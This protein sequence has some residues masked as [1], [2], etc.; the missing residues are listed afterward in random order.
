[1][2]FCPGF[3][4]LEGDLDNLI[5]KYKEK[6]LRFTEKQI[7]FWLIQICFAIEYIHKRRIIHRDIKASNIFLSTM[8][9]VK[10]GDFGISRV[11]E[12]SL[13]AAM[14]VVGTP[15][16]LSPELCQN[17]LY[18]IKTDIWALGCLLY[19]MCEFKVIFNLVT[20]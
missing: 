15:Y 7:M 20:F 12:N 9:I 3:H 8:E 14:T 19:E 13:E 5:K 6:N 16:Y 1:M 17:K 10:L 18:T 4:N 2:E 11:L